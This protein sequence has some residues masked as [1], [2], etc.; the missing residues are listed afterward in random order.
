MKFEC[1]FFALN[2]ANE[3]KTKRMVFAQGAPK[4]ETPADSIYDDV[5]KP[6]ALAN[7]YTNEREGFLKELQ[8]HAAGNV[9]KR[10]DSEDHRVR[11]SE[12]IEKVKQ[13]TVALD[14]KKANLEAAALKSNREALKSLRNQ[15]YAFKLD[16][17][18][19]E[20]D[21]KITALEKNVALYN[22]VYSSFKSELTASSLGKFAVNGV[23][24]PYAKW[25]AEALASGR[26]P[27]S[28]LVKSDQTIMA[29]SSEWLK[30]IDYLFDPE[31]LSALNATD[32]QE[33]VTKNLK[34]VRELR[35]QYRSIVKGVTSADFYEELDAKKTEAGTA[36][37]VPAE[38]KKEAG[39]DLKADRAVYE[40]SRNKAISVLMAYI[41]DPKVDKKQ[42]SFANAARTELSGRA[43]FDANET[44]L[45]DYQKELD[46]ILKSSLYE[47]ALTAFTQ[48]QHD[49]DAYKFSY[50]KL[51]HELSIAKETATESALRDQ[52]LAMLDKIER[53]PIKPISFLEAIDPGGSVKFRDNEIVLRSFREAAD[54]LLQAVKGAEAKNPNFDLQAKYGDKPSAKPV[55][56]PAPAQTK[57]KK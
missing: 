53:S 4:G 32:K 21:P 22:V 24:F 13:G 12:F 19:V 49:V 54:S 8:R 1:S 17:K 5:K 50:D 25:R 34:S 41:N 46:K 9:D 18:T 36:K 57:E 20:K 52:A 56:N 28:V 37:K 44:T 2:K 47:K 38:S 26:L 14:E 33:Y 45:N 3:F 30:K 55:A 10:F 7:I 27:E 42:V 23:D 40:E 39:T 16:K 11:A 51:L 48:L 31:A 43:G 35:D 6:D 29:R 15:F